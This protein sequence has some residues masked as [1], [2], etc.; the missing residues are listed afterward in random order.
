MEEDSNL[1]CRWGRNN[2]SESH[3][4]DGKL[5]NPTPALQRANAM[6]VPLHSTHL[7]VH[8]KLPE[9]SRGQHDGGVELNDVAFVQRDVMVGSE[10]LARVWG[11]G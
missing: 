10:T 4:C 8:E 5:H 11:V 2:A 1:G 9:V 3:P 7:H 6:L